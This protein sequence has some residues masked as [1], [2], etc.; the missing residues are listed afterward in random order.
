MEFG[1]SLFAGELLAG[2]GAPGF[3]EQGGKVA[4]VEVK[5]QTL[6]E[7]VERGG[8]IFSGDGLVVL[9]SPKDN[10][11]VGKGY[12]LQQF[13]GAIDPCVEVGLD[14]SFES[15]QALGEYIFTC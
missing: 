14:A 4:A 13:E 10:G 7:D 3:D 9:E 5:G 8:K 2:E 11:V 12:F 1:K 6:A 15:E